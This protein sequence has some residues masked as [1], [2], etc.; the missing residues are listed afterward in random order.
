MRAEKQSILD[1]IRERIDGS[2]YILL[3]DYSGLKVADMAELRKLLRGSHARL[4]VM[5]NTLVALSLDAGLRE[6]MAPVLTGPTAVV[7]GTG[8]VT[9]TAKV[10]K[11]FMGAHQSASVKG[12][13]LNNRV[14]TAADIEVLAS[15]PAREVLL[16]QV[17]GTVAAPMT[18]M[19][20]V[21]AA[22]VRSLLYVLRAVEEKKNNAAA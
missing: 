18:Q 10:L 21:M 8:D 19:V 12:G 3:A 16:S 13:C 5:K 1:E 20:G 15:L 9:E 22:K 2:D 4:Q 6:G 14:L 17:V 7:T 11:N